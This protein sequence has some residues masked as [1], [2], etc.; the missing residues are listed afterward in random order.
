[1]PDGPCFP[2]WHTFNRGTGGRNGDWGRSQWVFPHFNSSWNG[3][4]VCNCWMERVLLPAFPAL[5]IHLALHQGSLLWWASDAAP[6]LPCSVWVTQHLHGVPSALGIRKE[7]GSRESQQFAW[8]FRGMLQV[9][10]LSEVLGLTGQMKP[11]V[12]ANGPFL[13]VMEL[14]CSPASLLLFSC[15]HY[16]K[17]VLL[18]CWLPVSCLPPSPPPFPSAPHPPGLLTALLHMQSFFFRG[19]WWFLKLD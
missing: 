17:V 3:A 10:L 18:I 5:P 16:P 9:Q 12:P 8:H 14:A 19:E 11:F 13:A 15:S 1:M 2:L 6:P 7:A 4:G